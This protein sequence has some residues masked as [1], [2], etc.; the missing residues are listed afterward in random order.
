MLSCDK[1]GIDYDSG[2]DYDDSVFVMIKGGNDGAE[3]GL[4][5]I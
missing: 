4:L 5:T 3:D 1:N 2:G